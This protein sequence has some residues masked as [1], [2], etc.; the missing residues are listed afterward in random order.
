MNGQAVPRFP[1]LE[2]VRD[3]LNRLKITWALCCASPILYLLFSQFI[4]DMYFSAKDMGFAQLPANY[5]R[6]VVIGCAAVV[7]AMQIIMLIV[8]KRHDGEM[9]N[10]A[11]KSAPLLLSIYTK[12]TFKLMLL[13]EVAV[14]LGFVLFLLNG[15]I[16]VLFAFGIAAMLCYAQ[17]YPSERALASTIA[18]SK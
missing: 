9:R 8:R 10:T 7:V 18:P 14:L 12:R 1:Q 11:A 17:S 15:Q 5:Y 16:A 3:E 2:S 13:S 4:Q 6:G